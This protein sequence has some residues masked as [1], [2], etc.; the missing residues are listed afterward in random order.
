MVIVVVVVVVVASHMAKF[1][2][3][4]GRF[5]WLLGKTNNNQQDLGG[6]EKW[7]TDVTSDWLAEKRVK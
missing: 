4:V 2:E 1:G 5:C 3:H 7:T 6:R